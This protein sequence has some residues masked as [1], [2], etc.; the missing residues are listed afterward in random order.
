MERQNS[1]LIVDDDASNLMELA[2]ILKPEYKIYAV[3]DG[4]PALDKA[5]EA[6]P[7]LILLD[8][9]M[10]DM[11]GFE[12]L[13]ELKRSERTKD[14]PVIFITGVNDSESEREGLAIG[15][16]DYIRKPF[17]SM[18]VKHRVRLQVQILNLQ[19]DL[20]NAAEVAEAA[21]QSKSSFLANMSHEIRTPMNAIMGITDILLQEENAKQ[22]DVT[23]GLNKIYNSSEMLLNLIND[24]L[25]FSKIEAG[26]LDILPTRYKLAHMVNDTIHLN[27]M[28]IGEKPIKFEIDVPD[29]M[30]AKLV[31][32][33]LRIKQVLSNVLSNAFKYTEVGK[34]TMS[35]SHETDPESGEFILV[36]CVKDTGYGMTQEQLDALFDEY[37]RFNESSDRKIEGTG[38]GLSIMNRLVQL[39]YG[40]VHVESEPGKGTSVT[41]KLPQGIV[42]ANILGTKAADDLRQFR[43]QDAKGRESN[44]LHHEPMPYAKVLV[45]DDTETN[46]F[47]AVRFLKPYKLTIDTAVNGREAIEKINSEGGYDVVFMDHMMPEMDGMEAT[48]RL[49][50]TGYDRPIVALTANAMT[51][52]A[53]MF[54]SHGFDEFISKPI[55]IKLLDTVLMKLIRDKQ[56]QE[57]IDAARKQKAEEKSSGQDAMPLDVDDAIMES[58]IHD[59]RNAVAL[60]T[61]TY[62]KAGWT[63][64]EDDL[65]RF[66]ITVHGMKSILECIGEMELAVYAKE[67]EV[68][69]RAK[70]IGK[71]ESDAVSFLD[72]LNELLEKL[73]QE[74]DVGADVSGDG[75]G[76]LCEK[77]L[78]IEELCEEY[79]RKEV[80]DI[81][82]TVGGQLKKSSAVFDKIKELVLAS[83][84]EEAGSVAAEHAS[85]LSGA[86]QGGNDPTLEQE[87]TKPTLEGK[88]VEGLD[89][90]K[91]LERYDGDERLYL[92][93]LR[94][95]ASSTASMLESLAS[96]DKE[97]LNSYRIT[98]HGIKGAS[99]DIN[100][101]E[102]GKLA[103]DL[104]EAATSG[105]HE[106]IEKH[107][108]AFVKSAGEFIQKIN[109]LL[110][111][112][113]AEN[114]KPKKDKPEKRFL[115]L[116]H[117]AC[118]NYD[119]TGIDEA[120]VKIEKYEYDADDGLVDKL[121]NHVDLMQYKQIVTILTE[122]ITEEEL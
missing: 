82:S 103:E 75:T 58:F 118:E 79:D 19:R 67:L 106:Y 94:A 40:S 65:R 55:N 68:A 78:I 27:M 59:A 29:D 72:R 56:P 74:F 38:L 45:V 91:G 98:I 44:K 60:L 49:R 76:T 42:D 47:V 39:M 96:F 11:N 34:V 48:K 110:A 53:E 81:V 92:K 69:G 105:D 90:A 22:E 31:G 121:R 54:L 41:I 16:V 93:T 80:L 99:Y 2:S 8:V 52:Q 122:K 57:V 119:M 66:T 6:L 32:D 104:E 95:Y 114:P 14:I 86:S 115:Q 108:P 113:A 30:P 26:K 25:D 33:E 4:K 51:G 23:E 37:S 117:D 111:A 3:K 21:N 36:V 7:D 107:N 17:N 43:L 102:V 120:M 85:E 71:I 116:L 64:D 101:N 70:D 13:A 15:A 88:K 18:V 12:V 61:K 24:I 73:E 1:L 10:P 84:F 112:I 9:V 89:I 50:E 109:D 77:L 100:A 97:E 5:H 63:E 28:R 87:L 83:E 35:L 20:E 46:L 62:E